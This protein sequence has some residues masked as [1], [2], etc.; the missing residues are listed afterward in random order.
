MKAVLLGRPS[1]FPPDGVDALTFAQSPRIVTLTRDAEGGD[2]MTE[3]TR[4]TMLA[5]GVVVSAAAAW[6]LVN[7]PTARAAAPLAGKQAPGWYRI[8]VGNAEVTVIAEGARIGPLP[9]NFVR[10][11]SREEVVAALQAAFL[12]VDQ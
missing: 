4:R 1:L 9:D 6:P 10:N 12:P 11:K 2:A 5:G 3:L 7:Q 8:K